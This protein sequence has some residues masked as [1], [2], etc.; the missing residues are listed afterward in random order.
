VAHLVRCIQPR[1]AQPLITAEFQFAR[2]LDTGNPNSGNVGSDFNRFGLK[3]WIAVT[4]RQPT[5][6]KHQKA[7]TELNEWRNAIAHQSFD[8]AKLGGSTVLRHSQVK[9]WRKS[10]DLLASAFD[11]VL[12]N[13]LAA[14]TG[15]RPW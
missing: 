14:I 1:S 15:I 3:F 13:H 11:D 10:C 7:L 12:A 9:A 4:L 8:A 6:A 2:K 5:L